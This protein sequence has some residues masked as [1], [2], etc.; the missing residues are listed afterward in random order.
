MVKII[1][2]QEAYK[3]KIE[4][5]E[6]VERLKF[7]CYG[8]CAYIGEDVSPGCYPCFYS[9][10]CNYGFMLGRHV[11]LPNVCN[12]DC[13]YCFEPHQVQQNYSVPAEWVISEEQKDKAR[14]TFM[15]ARYR[16]TTDCKMQYYE[17]TGV[18]E[19]LLYLPVL[20]EW[21]K[22]FRNEIDP[23]MGTKGWA[24]VYTNGTLLNQD[25]ILKLK[26]LGFDEVRIHPGATNFSKEVYDNMRLA[27]KDI[28]VVT[29]ETPS[30][31]PHRKKL[32]EMLPIIEDIGVKHLDICQIEIT[33]KE[34]LK[35]IEKA[36]G[37]IELYQA[38]YPVMDDGGLV[39]DIM[40]EVVDK[41]YS[42]SV[43]DCNGFVKQSRS[44]LTNNS[45]WNL[46]NQKYPP[47]WEKQRYDRRLP[48]EAAITNEF[49][50]KGG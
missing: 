42:Y 45:Y 38:F 24:K 50:K 12:R 43:I 1:P 28:P 35:K 16:I 21:M 44:A 46:L 6:K 48:I 2:I 29:V 26:D 41:D 14:R 33:N 7:Q 25:N 31:P 11:G 10:A 20:E 36:L 5:Q 15:A 47:Q 37:E 32:F 34:Q 13:V 8:S 30:W 19:P 22:F 9:D 39:E 4:R 27:V 49:V 40:R 3:R 23:F 17:F 18:S